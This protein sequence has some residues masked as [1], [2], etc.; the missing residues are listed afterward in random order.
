MMSYQPKY[1]TMLREAGI[2]QIQLDE[3]TRAMIEKIEQA[4][5]AANDE[6]DNMRRHSL[7]RII[8]QADAIVCAILY[9]TFGVSLKTETE[10]KSSIDKAKAM[11]F[12]AKA[13]QLIRRKS[14]VE[15]KVYDHG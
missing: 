2:K 12:K 14:E 3:N 5:V 6:K 11:A 1:L 8:A 13:L 15:M 7:L 9:K 10:S 4:L